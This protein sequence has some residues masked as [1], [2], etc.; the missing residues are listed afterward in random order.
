[1]EERSSRIQAGAVGFVADPTDWSYPTTEADID[2]G[3]ADQQRSLVALVRSPQ[4]VVQYFDVGGAAPV[5]RGVFV[6]DDDIDDLLRRPNPKRITPG[7]P[8]PEL[9]GFTPM[10]PGQPKLCS[11]ASSAA[12]ST[13]AKRC[14]LRPETNANF[15]CLTLKIFS[16]KCS[17][18]LPENSERQLRC[19]STPSRSMW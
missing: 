7:T 14:V 5:V 6:A 17:A 2:D 19:L 11:T 4:M 16:A 12:P 18:V 15:G 9:M 3:E 1:M 8:K 13:F 10:R